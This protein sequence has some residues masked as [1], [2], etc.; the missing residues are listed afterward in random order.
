M[1]VTIHA[2]GELLQRARVGDASAFAELYARHRAAALRLARSYGAGGDAEDLVHAAFERVMGAVRRGGGPDE[3]FRPYLY[4]TL[5]HLAI[6]R[7]ARTDHERLD[8]VPE[9]VVAVSGLP[10]MD[11]SER[12]LIAEAFSG[13][14]ERWQAVLWLIAVEGRPPREVARAT[15]LPANTV[16]V[17]AHRARERLRQTYLQAHV[18]AFGAD[19]CAPHRSRLGAYVRGGLS[20]RQR[21]AAAEHVASCESCG[22]LVAELDD[23]NR[24][25]ARAVLPVFAI[26]AEEGLALGVGAAGTAGLS[27][28]AGTGAS[29]TGAA[30]SGATAG[31]GVGVLAKAAALV[32]AVVGLV[33]LVALAPGDRGPLGDDPPTVEARGP[34]A[35]SDHGAGGPSGATPDPSVAPG[36]SAPP[37][38]AAP[39]APSVPGTAGDVVAGVEADLGIGLTADAAGVEVRADVEAGLDTGVSVD[40]A[41]TV[42]PLG[43]G[44]LAVEVANPDPAPLLDVEVVVDLS[45]G[46]HATTLVGSGC[47]TS[48]PAVLDVVA[49]LLRSLTCAL[50]EVPRSGVTITLPLEVVG[51]DQSA[52]IRVQDGAAVLATTV[53]PLAPSA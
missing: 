50:D 35:G 4:V 3:A 37:A 25:L 18:S 26:G 44:T 1:A 43:A 36:P 47:D 33:G 15:G 46:A 12:A 38:S 48:D 52:A 16:S 20:R 31:V 40:A 9:G 30:V 19:R 29:A 41:W 34:V 45:P 11:G 39:P 6:E 8:D 21:A 49:R 10:A 28:G 53:V 51:P 13:L 32:A 27:A 14:P 2:D 24:L 22:R 5:R 42:G 7:A 17:L 23:V